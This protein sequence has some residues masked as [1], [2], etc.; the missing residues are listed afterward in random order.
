MFRFHK[1]HGLS[2]DFVI[3][4]GREEDIALTGEQIAGLANRRTGIGFDQLVILKPPQDGQADIFMDMYNADGSSLEACGNASRCVASLLM[5]EK[6]TNR[7]I[8][9]TV[10]GFLESS[11]ANEDKTLVTVDMG[12]PG[13]DW[14][15]IPL[16]VEGDTLYLPDLGMVF[17]FTPVGETDA[18]KASA[19]SMGNPHCVFFVEDLGSV[20]LEEAGPLIENHEMFP[21]RTNVEFI[22]ID[23]RM[24]LR[25]R[26]WE[27]GAGIT[28]ACGSGACAS[29]VAAVR[30]G[31][32]ERR[33]NVQ[34]DGGLLEIEWNEEG[35]H[36]L[37]TGAATY[38]FEGTI[39]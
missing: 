27:R 13:L 3:I 19:V 9:Q 25:M 14:R 16:A 33:C 7:V 38:V 12:E 24:N 11:G 28:A 1:M 4:D 22:S 6:R 15:D 20:N 34:L 32:A 26:V 2:N 17:N 10:A 29:V 35:N 36:V 31:L 37:M 18:P 5:K 39:P 30:R 21:N 23:D 8:L